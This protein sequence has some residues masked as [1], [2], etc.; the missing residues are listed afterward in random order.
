MNYEGPTI[1]N[2][3]LALAGPPP[4]GNGRRRAL[5]LAAVALGLVVIG[6]LAFG[7]SKPPA[8][9]PVSSAPSVYRASLALDP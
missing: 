4:A 7:R 1:S 8:A 2:E 9:A 6:W 3:R 5:I